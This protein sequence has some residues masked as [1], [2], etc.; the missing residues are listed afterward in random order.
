MPATTQAGLL[1]SSQGEFPATPSH[2]PLL[3]PPK[4]IVLFPAQSLSQAKE[5]HVQN[6]L[7]NLLPYFFGALANLWKGAH[8]PFP[9]PDF[10]AFH[11]RVFPHV[12]LCSGE[13]SVDSGDLG[14]STLP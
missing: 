7:G 4:G 14:T 5:I 1:L 3:R 2:N 6:I 11:I 10:R 9:I 13:A 8:V 12:P